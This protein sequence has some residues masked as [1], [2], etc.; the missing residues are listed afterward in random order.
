MRILPLLLAIAFPLS[1]EI[2]RNFSARAAMDPIRA[3]PP[4]LASRR[5]AAALANAVGAG[6]AGPAVAEASSS[7]FTGSTMRKSSTA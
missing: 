4:R 5:S 3:G 1:A 6:F 7:S 2:G